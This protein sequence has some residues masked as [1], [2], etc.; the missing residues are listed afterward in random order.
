M[1]GD[2]D[3][4]IQ[5]PKKPK[6]AS[7]AAVNA[8]AAQLEENFAQSKQVCQD[9]LQAHI[10]YMQRGDFEANGAFLLLWNRDGTYIVNDAGLLPSATMIGLLEIAKQGFLLRHAMS[11][12]QMPVATVSVAPPTEDPPN[13]P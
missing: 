6:P 2:N 8:E 13:G 7:P 9:F 11:V 3:N 5:F 10:N 1:A 4:T 12:T